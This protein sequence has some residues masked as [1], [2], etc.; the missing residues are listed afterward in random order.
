MMT[1]IP[2]TFAQLAVAFFCLVVPFTLAVEDSPTP[3]P[4]TS[5]IIH[6]SNTSEW[7]LVQQLELSSGSI[8][9]KLEL[10]ANV[11]GTRFVASAGASSAVS[12]YHLQQPNTIAEGSR[13]WDLL[14]SVVYSGDAER[15]FFDKAMSG[16]GTHF[17]GA[18]SLSS[19]RYVR[20]RG[21]V[22]VYATTDG[23]ANWNIKFRTA[24]FFEKNTPEGFVREAVVGFGFSNRVAISYNGTR[25]AFPVSIH[26]WRGFEWGSPTSQQGFHVYEWNGTDYQQLGETLLVEGGGS[27]FQ[28]D[29]SGAFLLVDG[30][31]YYYRKKNG[32][33]EP[34]GGEDLPLALISPNG[35]RV[36]KIENERVVI[37]QHN[38]NTHNWDEIAAIQAPYSESPNGY[39]FGFSVDWGKDGKTLIVGAPTEERPRDPDQERVEGA[40]YV[41]QEMECTKEPTSGPTV[42]PSVSSS[43]QPTSSP[44]V[45]TPSGSPTS[46]ATSDGPTSS[47]SVTPSADKVSCAFAQV[48]NMPCSGESCGR[49]VLISADG[50][51]ILN[52]KYI[53]DPRGWNQGPRGW[54]LMSYSRSDAAPVDMGGDIVGED[55]NSTPSL[56][57]SPTASLGDGNEVGEDTSS[58]SSLK[59]SSTPFP[60]PSEVPTSLP[61][62]GYEGV[63]DTTGE[64]ETSGAASTAATTIVPLLLIAFAMTAF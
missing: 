15:Y 13:T 58:T 64:G 22:V 24:G 8:I 45:S 5:P 42:S 12:I 11:D 28:M 49:Y 31:Q 21:E 50:Q 54:Y 25:L 10:S 18:M 26:K 60:K 47:P 3:K 4:T 16:D 44:S 6:G 36:A 14:A 56:T 57:P 29:W 41:F 35:S 51:R 53:E 32:R 30:I 7:N 48:G 27:S 46:A 20:F 9:Y 43:E 52:S 33:W 34:S 55:T 1:S 61:G 17:V 2:T 62:E 19:R 23:G 38:D 39:S 63:E 40:V 37:F 59:P